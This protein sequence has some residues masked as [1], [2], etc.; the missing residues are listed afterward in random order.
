[1]TLK[2]R[3]IFSSLFLFS[4]SLAAPT[5]RDLHRFLEQD[6]SVEVKT[7]DFATSDLISR[8]QMQ[9]R[10]VH[11][12]TPTG[13]SLPIL[14][15]VG[16]KLDSAHAI[17]DLNIY[18]RQ[19]LGEYAV[20]AVQMNQVRV[21]AYAGLKDSFLSYLD[22]TVGPKRSVLQIR[23]L[24]ED[25]GISKYLV[26]VRGSLPNLYFLIPPSL[27]YA[28]H[29]AT[30]IRTIAP[31]QGISVFLDQEAFETL[32]D[33]MKA[34][35]TSIR[36]Q[37]ENG[38]DFVVFGYRS[39]WA[40]LLSRGG[41]WTLKRKQ[42]FVE[43]SVGLAADLVVVEHNN[44]RSIRR[45]LLITS[46]RTV[47]GELAGLMIKPFF[48]ENLRA[49]VFMGSAGAV[50]PKNSIYDISIP[51]RFLDSSG[52]ITIQNFF[53]AFGELSKYSGFNFNS[54][55]GDTFS[56]IEQD[57]S[58][59]ERLVAQEFD[60]ID[61]EQNIVA[62]KVLNFN[63]KTKAAIQFGAVNLITDKPYDLLKTTTSE[64]GLDQIDH[65]K[66]NLARYRAVSFV[67][68]ALEALS[69]PLISEKCGALF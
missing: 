36:N 34:A 9:S 2:V 4:T 35:A 43:P 60:T 31:N 67:L 56:P 51:K 63:L 58:F 49:V 27:K 42:T 40:D 62:R 14:P 50:S 23:S 26:T 18:V 5:L 3:W 52:E 19:R 47:W 57:R 17:S 38:Y 44:N 68:S 15:I 53:S 69:P 32:K 12:I 7:A 24:Y 65:T 6:F 66:K 55:H 1:M 13:K 21:Y 54:I 45:L 46:R 39:V 22:Q 59:L 20:A 48:H 25:W 37:I 10:K 16:K 41:N 29:Y 64:Y 30:M 61:V 33:Q 8:I 11:N 28:L